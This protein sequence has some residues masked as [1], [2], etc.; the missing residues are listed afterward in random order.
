MQLHRPQILTRA[1]K[2]K[3]LRFNNIFKAGGKQS[4]QIKSLFAHLQSGREATDLLGGV[5]S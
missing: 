4:N 3:S 1:I 2:R 5:S